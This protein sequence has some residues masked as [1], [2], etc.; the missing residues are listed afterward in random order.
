MSEMSEMS[1]KD[2]VKDEHVTA[3][4]TKYWCTKGIYK[5]EGK[6]S[7]RKSTMLCLG[8]SIYIHKP[9][10]HLTEE[11]ARDHV[12]ELRVKRLT[13]LQKTIRKVEKLS[14]Q[15]IFIQNWRP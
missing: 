10:W 4:V 15:T 7:G 14:P 5:V 9:Y 13:S 3:Y 12:A 6:I 2:E 1:D 11:A 8:R